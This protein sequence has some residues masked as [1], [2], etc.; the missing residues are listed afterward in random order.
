[1]CKKCDIL[2]EA[3]GEEV[4]VAAIEGLGHRDEEEPLGFNSA[5]GKVVDMVV[6]RV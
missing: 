5:G 3:R 4:S 1:M 6:V 2:V